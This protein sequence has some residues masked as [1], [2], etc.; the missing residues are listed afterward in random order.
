MDE[1][2]VHRLRES[3]SRELAALVLKPQEYGARFT[4]ADSA[5]RF[6][7]P[8]RSQISDYAQ[9]PGL[10]QPDP[11]LVDTINVEEKSCGDT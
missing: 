2:A 7:E 5:A 10:P 1:K 4:S 3:R 6:V 11:G 9:F 8:F